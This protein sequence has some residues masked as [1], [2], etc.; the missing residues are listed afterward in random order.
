MAQVLNWYETVFELIDMRSFSNL[1]FWIALAVI[2]STSSHW[3]LGVPFDLVVRARKH[4]GGVQ[5][6][7]NDMVRVNVNRILFIART[8][9]LWLLALGSFVLTAAALLGFVYGVEFAQAFFLL[10]FP[11]S[12][13]WG[14]SVRTAQQ[15]LEADGADLHARM[16][17]HR[18]YVQIIGVFSIFVTALWGM[19][20]NMA[21]GPL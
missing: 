16:V 14:L 2:W 3:I 12:V 10:G 8:S 1:W 13:V 6:D 18:I 4:G 20:Q 11:L 19:Y 7:L 21:V 15:I 5:D 17:R 9:G